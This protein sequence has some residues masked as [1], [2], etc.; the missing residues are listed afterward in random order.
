MNGN[1]NVCALFSTFLIKVN[2]SN[3]HFN[4]F[5]NNVSLVVSVYPNICSFKK[6]SKFKN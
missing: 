2:G 6:R 1:M 5:I 4:R 3:F